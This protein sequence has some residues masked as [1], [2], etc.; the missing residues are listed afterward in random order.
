[1]NQDQFFKC[2]KG[3][4]YD[5]GEL[6][7]E[8]CLDSKLRTG[9]RGKRRKKRPHEVKFGE[10]I[11][12]M[13]ENPELHQLQEEEAN[14]WELNVRRVLKRAGLLLWETEFIINYIVYEMTAEEILEKEEDK[15]VKNLKSP[16]LVSYHYNRLIN[17]LREL[18]IK[19]D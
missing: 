4:P 10:K 18:N 17:K 1:M 12:R 11:E 2:N 6:I 14:C 5:N 9:K 15:E 19:F 7:C 13:P 8:R 3:C 16:Q